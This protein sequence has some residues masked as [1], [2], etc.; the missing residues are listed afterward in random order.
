MDENKTLISLVN[1]SFTIKF[2]EKEFTAR[3]ANIGHVAQY[4]T[5]VVELSKDE[6]IPPAARDAKLIAY[7]TYLILK[8]ADS[9]VTLE[10]VENN[11]PGNTD[12]L[13]LLCTLGF[14]DPQKAEMARKMQEKLISDAS[15]QP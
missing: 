4:Q 3:K 14:I 7:C 6:S 15:S 10:Y 8:E 9:T 5:K 2:G 12:G 11:L 1:P 13:E